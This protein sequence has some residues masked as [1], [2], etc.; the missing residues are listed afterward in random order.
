M[1]R[2]GSQFSAPTLAILL[3]FLL[4]FAPEV[5][6]QNDADPGVLLVRYDTSDLFEDDADW[7]YYDTSDPE[8][9]REIM[10]QVIATVE[11]A[12]GREPRASQ[13]IQ[14]LSYEQVEIW[15]SWVDEPERVF[16]AAG[17]VLRHIE[18]S[19][20]RIAMAPDSFSAVGDPFPIDYPSD[21]GVYNVS[22]LL[23][24]TGLGL[25]V[26]ADDR[27]DTEG[28]SI[29]WDLL[30]IGK[31]ADIFSDTQIAIYD[32]IA[33]VASCDP[34]GAVCA[35]AA[36]NAETYRLLGNVL[37]LGLELLEVPIMLCEIQD[38]NVDAAEIEAGYENGLTSLDAEIDTQ[39]Q[40][41]THDTDIKTQIA[42]QADDIQAQIATHDTDIKAQI[43]TH[44]TDLKAQVTT[45]DTDIKAL[46]AAMLA[47][48]EENTARLKSVQAVQKQIIKLQ[49]TPQGRRAVDETDVLTCLGDACPNVLDCPG[50]ECDFPLH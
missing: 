43:T 9:F 10:L 44:D 41:V 29:Y 50:V 38:G 1:S 27:C 49:L 34:I 3:L 28:W 32:A 19:R 12:T 17:S 36:L 24:L 14:E 45:H 33:T 13:A 39:N 16:A 4:S 46:L 30:V 23:P 8:A 22:V 37:K 35:A 21:T 42:M 5:S 25:I 2:N 11:E 47:A 26:N 20:S 18:E 40:I 15:L 7:A 6:A 48:I 31:S